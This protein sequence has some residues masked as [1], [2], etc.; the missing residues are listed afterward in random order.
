M[1]SRA[2]ILALL[3]TLDAMLAG[4]AFA[5]SFDVAVVTTYSGPAANAGTNLWQGMRVA[6]RETDGHPEE[7][8]DGHL[9]GVDSNLLRIDIAADRGMLATRLRPITGRQG[10]AVIVFDNRAGDIGTALSLPAP[11]VILL[12]VPANRAVPAHVLDPVALDAATTREFEAQYRSQYGEKPN[13]SARL[14]YTAARRIA[15]ALRVLDG[16]LRDP[17]AVLDVFR[18]ARPS[19]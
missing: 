15:R 13:E 1:S 6:T 18:R 14:G 3:L 5:H 7:T 10:T 19:P 12:A 16:D 2:R 4:N 11:G 8:S 9:G 17:P